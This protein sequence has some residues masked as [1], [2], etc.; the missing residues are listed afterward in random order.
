[1]VRTA[2]AQKL[3]DEPLIPNKDDR[4]CGPLEQL[5]AEPPLHSISSQNDNR[6]RLELLFRLAAGEH[7]GRRS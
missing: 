4:L 3:T 6:S 5:S 1:M 7:S 2:K